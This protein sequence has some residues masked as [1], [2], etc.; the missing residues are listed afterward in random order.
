VDRPADDNRASFTGSGL[1]PLS[2]YSSVADAASPT[3][4][5]GVETSSEFRTQMRIEEDV[6]LDFCDVLIRPKRSFAPSRKSV[7]LHCEYDFKYGDN[8]AKE[9]KSC[10]PI[11]AANMATTGTFA[12]ARALAPHGVMTCLHKHYLVDDLIKFFNYDE[13]SAKTFY[14]L[15]IKDDD[16]EKLKQFIDKHTCY[17]HI[18][19]DAANGY[20]QYF[21]D[22][23][24][25]VREL[26]PEAVIMAGNV[27]TPE[28]VQE[29]ILSGGVDIVKI[30]IGPGSVCTTRIVTGVGYPQLSAIIECADAAHGLDGHIC[31]DGGCTT[32]GEINKA[33][34]AGADFVMLG[35]MLSGTDECEGE[36]EYDLVS[37]WVDVKSEDGSTRQLTAYDQHKK[38]L[39]FYG[40]SSTEAMNKF[41]G[42]QAKYRAAEGKSVSVPYKGPVEAVI[43]QIKG[44][45]VG[46]CTLVGTEELKHLSKSTTFVKVNRTHNRVYE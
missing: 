21:L 41:Y 26:C 5:A 14:T 32:S 28:M 23:C 22:R 1:A 44:G 30:G 4:I 3:G 35:G 19:I 17:K 34:G 25:Q 42:G 12:M 13:A 11:I 43:D 39:K 9:Y 38:A 31:A 46:G 45:I 20:T 15:G 37:K 24:K 36:W 18:C 29:L 6:K 7:N 27:A 8:S 33:F 10:I 16:F 2:C 40:M